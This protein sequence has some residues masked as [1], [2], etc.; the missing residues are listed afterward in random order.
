MSGVRQVHPEFSRPEQHVGS[1]RVISFLELLDICEAIESGCPAPFTIFTHGDF[2]A[3]NVVYDHLEER[4]HYIDVYRSRPADYVQD[5]SVFLVSNFRTPVFDPDL[6]ERL[7]LITTKFLWFAKRFAEK[8]GDTTFPFRLT[9]ALAR[10]FYTSTRFELDAIFANEM[11]L[12][13]IYLLE[14]IAAHKGKPAEDFVLPEHIL[15][16]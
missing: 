7:N 5:V 14:K 6:R 11:Y 13:A 2:N 12:R 16:Y 10:S 8:H 4:I 9:M 1:A 15:Y 3:N